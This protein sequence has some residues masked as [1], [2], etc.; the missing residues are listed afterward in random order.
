VT[1]EELII[2]M[3]ETKLAIADALLERTEEGDAVSG[4]EGRDGVIAGALDV[5]ELIELMR[6]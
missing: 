3:H 5:D 1:I 4:E 2:E 6:G